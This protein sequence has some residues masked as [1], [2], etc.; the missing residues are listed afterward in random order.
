MSLHRYL[1]LVLACTL[2]LAA[3]TRASPTAPPT[4]APTSAATIGAAAAATGTP[5][6]GGQTT[7]GAPVPVST[8]KP[9]QSTAAEIR[10][11]ERRAE[12]TR[13][14]NLLQFQVMA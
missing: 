14:S 9:P 10:P 1:S 7:Q 2:L 6:A 5:D 13:L 4:S 11:P 8:G 3:C 12:L